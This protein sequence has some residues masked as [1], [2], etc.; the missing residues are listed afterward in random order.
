MKLVIGIGLALVILAVYGVRRIVAYYNGEP[1]EELMNDS[2]NCPGR[3]YEKVVPY[4]LSQTPTRCLVCNT[5]T[6]TTPI[7]PIVTA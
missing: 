6:A 4:G 5:C 1:C 3:M 2:T 7:D